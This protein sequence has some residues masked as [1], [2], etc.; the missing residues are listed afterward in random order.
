M[1]RHTPAVRKDLLAM[2]S[3]LIT[4]AASQ[5][6]V[7]VSNPNINRI[8]QYNTDWAVSVILEIKAAESGT[9][10]LI[11]VT[12]PTSGEQGFKITSIT[13][14][15]IEIAYGNSLS[16]NRISVETPADFIQ[17]NNRYHIV[18]NYIAASQDLEVW[19]NKAKK[20]FT[21]AAKDTL[22]ATPV[23]SD[24][25]LLIGKRII[26]A[27]GSYS[28]L[29]IN[30]LSFFNRTLSGQEIEYIYRWG[31]QVP[32]G[33]H[34]NCLAHYVAGRK[35]YS[36]WDNVNQYDYG[37]QTVKLYHNQDNKQGWTGGARS[38]SI[39]VSAFSTMLSQDFTNKTVTKLLIELLNQTGNADLFVEIYNADTSTV[40]QQYL[41][42]GLS[43]MTVDLSTFLS[44]QSNV[45]V[46]VV[47]T[48]SSGEFNIRYITYYHQLAHYHGQ[49]TNYTDTEVGAVSMETQ[50]AYQDF[51]THATLQWWRDQDE[52]GVPDTDGSGFYLEK[53]SGLA[54][55]Q[56]A[57]RFK[58][59]SSQYVKLLPAAIP[60]SP[61][62]YIHCAFVFHTEGTENHYMFSGGHSATNQS[63][64]NFQ[65]KDDQTL[66]FYFRN[67]QNHSGILWSLDGV[68]ALTLRKDQ[69]YTATIVCYRPTEASPYE[70][71]PYINGVKVGYI[72][73]INIQDFFGRWFNQMYGHTAYN[74]WSSTPSLRIGSRMYNGASS[75]SQMS[76]LD[77]H[78]SDRVPSQKEILQWHNNTLL[79]HARQAPFVKPDFNKIIDDTAS[80]GKYLLDDLSG[81]GR[82]I[83]AIGFNATHL[84]PQD[85]NYSFTPIDNLR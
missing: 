39:Y 38:T 24:A 32:K 19:I 2:E 54:A 22:T 37:R 14:N 41:F 35:G 7:T 48:G 17:L 65:V 73:I 53:K 76:V 66:Q 42:N 20:S 18:V 4:E 25:V 59:A 29:A 67:S 10:W 27:G 11:A 60:Y 58:P 69:L 57:L 62:G 46:R 1:V 78:L 36:L 26:G 79:A 63:I 3:M 47:Y 16:A 40:V 55:H 70:W 80:S 61:Q 85:P 6:H 21:Y 50:T 44:T 83:E 56:N 34:T 49:L 64:F 28:S 75:F 5:Q 9:P 84:D 77:F 82:T 81:Q 31:G 51:Y 15:K 23:P 74:T 30:H 13:S 8:L 45:T 12:S 72:K 43:Q 68:N 33:L 71:V 52:N